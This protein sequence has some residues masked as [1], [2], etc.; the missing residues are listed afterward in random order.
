MR[1]ILLTTL[2]FATALAGCTASDDTLRVAF[3][4]KDTATAP[5]QELDRLAAYLE[6]ETGLDTSVTF[7]DDNNL[8]WPASPAS[9]APP[10]GSP[11]N[12]LAWRPSGAKCA[13]M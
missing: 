10:H 1:T 6:A 13:A 2:L 4:A 9:T 7:S 3:V 5:H 12:A 11:G 8:A